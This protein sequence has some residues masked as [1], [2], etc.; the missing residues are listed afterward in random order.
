MKTALHSQG[1]ALITGASS[2]IGAVFA[3]KLAQRGLDLVLTARRKDRLERMAEDLED[4]CGV[5]VH[6]IAADLA[7]NDG[8]ETVARWIEEAEELRLL[9]NNAGFGLTG[10]FLKVPYKDH[11]TMVTVHVLAAVRLCYAALPG[12][13]RRGRGGI[14]NV[15]SLSAFMPMG[16]GSTYAPTKAYLN[17]FSRN[18]QFE[19]RS[20]GVRIQA[21]CP[22]FTRTEFHDDPSLQRMK[23]G[24]PGFLWMEAD[25]VV[26]GSLAALERGK[27]IYIPGT[28]NR[29]IALAARS[30]LIGFFAPLLTRRMGR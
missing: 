24:I 30:G 3:E 22:G 28:R 15:S 4:R 25:R 1:T 2:G 20:T 5:R 6:V 7:E 10:S 18:L 9:V 8:L 23:K 19:M 11:Q 12:M 14:I 16:S 13:V 29:L 26:N 21:L 27:V 17:S